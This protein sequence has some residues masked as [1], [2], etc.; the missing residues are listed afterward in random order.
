MVLLESLKNKG[1]LFQKFLI[2]RSY[3]SY[4]ELLQLIT[5]C[6]RIQKK[7]VIKLAAL[8]RSMDRF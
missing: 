1:P 3:D 6:Y 4:S 5:S 7:Y 2:I 8:A